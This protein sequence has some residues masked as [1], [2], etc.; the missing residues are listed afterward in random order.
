MLFAISVAATL[1]VTRLA[2]AQANAEFS[3]DAMDFDHDGALYV[4]EVIAFFAL[5][6]GANGAAAAA[7]A[8][9]GGSPTAKELFSRWDA[10]CDGK[11]TR[12]EFDARTQS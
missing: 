10:N 3:F 8:G 12:A 2:S 1:L 9:V 7:A 6:R 4:D 5:R 11:V